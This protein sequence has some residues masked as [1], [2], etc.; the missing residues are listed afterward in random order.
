MPK[1]KVTS[2]GQITIP[3]SVRRELNLGPGDEIEFYK[4]HGVI[5]VKKVITSSPF[6]PW[7][8]FLKH[9]QGCDPDELVREMRGD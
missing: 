1:A 3:V 8:G 9:L 5:Q 7:I 6:E 2:K 4:D